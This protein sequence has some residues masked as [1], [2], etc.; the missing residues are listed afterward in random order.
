M[1]VMEDA[2]SVQLDQAVDTVRAQTTQITLAQ[3]YYE[4]YN[5]Q[6]Y[7]NQM[8]QQMYY[9]YNA[10]QNELNAIYHTFDA[11]RQA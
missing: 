7:Q 10:Y 8:Y 3:S 6:N 1:Q 5:F 2:Y 4:Q 9:N 11:Q